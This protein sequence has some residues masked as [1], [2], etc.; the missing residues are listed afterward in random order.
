MKDT[1]YEKLLSHWT[2]VYWCREKCS[3]SERAWYNGYYEALNFMLELARKY[4][5]EEDNK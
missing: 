3:P 2:Y 5:K 1:Y 4:R